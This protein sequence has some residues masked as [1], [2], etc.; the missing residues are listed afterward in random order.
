MAFIRESAA[1]RDMLDNRCLKSF[2]TKNEI[3]SSSILKPCET[4]NTRPK[5]AKSH[6]T[7]YPISDKNRVREILMKTRITF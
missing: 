3:L 6:L 1:H 2:S 7:L 4:T 5:R